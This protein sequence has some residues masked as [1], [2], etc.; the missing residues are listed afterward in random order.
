ME[1]RQEHQR[2]APAQAATGQAGQGDSGRGRLL[3]RL[4]AV[5]GL[6][7][8]GVALGAGWV[9]VALER[10]ALDAARER[11]DKYEQDVAAMRW[12]LD[13]SQKALAALEGRFIIEESTRRGLETSLRTAQTELGRARDTIAFYE[14]LM[15]PGPSGAVSVRALDIERSGPNLK[16]RLLVMRSGGSDKPFRGTLQFLASGRMRGEK[17]TLELQSITIPAAPGNA[18]GVGAASTPVHAD[19]PP[20]PPS[21]DPLAL[22]F[23]EFQR[24]SGVLGIPADFVPESVTVNVLEGRTL[25]V[26]RSIELPP[27]G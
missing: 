18:S 27:G 12:R 17:A 2:A 26:S 11:I 6:L 14:E 15:P 7:A 20:G 1:E 16:Y 8:V 5:F 25:R 10:P 21:A 4:V 13:E 24:S 9:F 23:S 19:Q 3:R 22:D